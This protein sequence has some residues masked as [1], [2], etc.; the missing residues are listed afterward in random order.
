MDLVFSWMDHLGIIF[1]SKL[2]GRG[3]L[4][5]REGLKRDWWEKQATKA[6]SSTVGFVWG[7]SIL[8]AKLYLTNWLFGF[9]WLLLFERST[10]ILFLKNWVLDSHNLQLN[11][12]SFT[13]GYALN[14]SGGLPKFPLC[15]EWWRSNLNTTNPNN[16]N[17]IDTKKTFNTT[18][19]NNT[20]T[21]NI[22]QPSYNTKPNSKSKPQKKNLLP[23]RH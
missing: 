19:P 11:S 12:F 23:L 8:C 3:N 22:T 4:L 1:I 10:T 17:T 18:N 9:C 13:V 6:S 21:L 7:S 2:V 5:E 15:Y 14:F 20:N 16:T